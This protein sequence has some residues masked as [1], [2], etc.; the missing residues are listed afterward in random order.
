M[1]DITAPVP[2]EDMKK[3][4]Q[5]CLEKAARI[6]YSQ[7]MDYAQIKGESTP[8][9]QQKKKYGGEKKMFGAVSV[10]CIYLPDPVTADWLLISEYSF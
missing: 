3:L 4:V 8:V 1:K 10:V 7:L 9:K 5:R 2:S 6:N